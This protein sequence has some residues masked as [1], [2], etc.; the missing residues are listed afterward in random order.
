MTLSRVSMDDL[1]A[2]SE[3]RTQ[4]ILSESQ[5]DL[6]KAHLLRNGAV[7]QEF[8]TNTKQ[9]HELRAT[10][11]L[12]DEKC[13]AQIQNYITEVLKPASSRKRPAAAVGS[14]TPP[15]AQGSST[16]QKAAKPSTQRERARERAAANVLGGNIVNAFALANRVGRYKMCSF[17]AAGW[18]LV[19]VQYR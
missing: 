5:V 7:A 6:L 11:I 16:Q 13:A 8:W 17:P 2:L 15:A 1:S 18:H 19:T 10:G 12:S 3:C 4:R 9:V 14:T